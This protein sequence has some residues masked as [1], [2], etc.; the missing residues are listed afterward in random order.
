MGSDILSTYC[1]IAFSDI[2]RRQSFFMKTYGF[3]V[4]IQHFFINIFNEIFVDFILLF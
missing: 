2:L 4:A 1:E 3:I